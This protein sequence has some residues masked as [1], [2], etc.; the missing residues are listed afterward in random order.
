MFYLSFYQMISKNKEDRK[1]QNF[2]NK[3]LSNCLFTGINIGGGLGILFDHNYLNCMPRGKI[4]L[5][6][7]IKSDLCDGHG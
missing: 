4:R 1:N 6:I 7:L 3:K 2:D 5:K